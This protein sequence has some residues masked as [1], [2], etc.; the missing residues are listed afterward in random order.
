MEILVLV[1]RHGNFGPCGQTENVI[2][3]LANESYLINI[4]NYSS[5]QSGYT[6]DFSASTALIFDVTPPHVVNDTLACTQTSLR[7]KFNEPVL[8]NLMSLCFAIPLPH[9]VTI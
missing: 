8:C 9:P 7:V 3:V 2:T 5:S 6:I 1:V 4:S